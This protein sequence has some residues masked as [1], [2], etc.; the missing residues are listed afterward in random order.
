MIRPCRAK[1]PAPPV[2]AASQFNRESNRGGFKGAFGSG[3]PDAQDRRAFTMLAADG[4]DT[5]MDRD[6]GPSAAQG[7][8]DYDQRVENDLG[9][10]S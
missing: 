6:H 10:C 9:N 7:I 8:A 1:N 2:S 5:L 3:I 4:L